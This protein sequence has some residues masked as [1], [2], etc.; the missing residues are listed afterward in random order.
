MR[1]QQSLFCEYLV[2]GVSQS[3]AY[4]LAYPSCKSKGAARASA[5]KLLTNPNVRQRLDELQKLT[6]T[7][8]T[9]TWQR[10]REILA[11]IAEDPNCTPAER[12]AAIRQDCLMAGHDKPP[13]GE[14]EG[15][16]SLVDI[17]RGLPET[18]GLPYGQ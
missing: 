13:Q 4:R 1:S 7:K 12:I 3:A 18:T 2:G 10:K 15:R 8:K 6:Q 11:K 9:L 17:I 14:G 16:L 5:S